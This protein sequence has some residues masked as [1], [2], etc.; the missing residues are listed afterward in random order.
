M[1]IVFSDSSGFDAVDNMT[2]EPP[3]NRQLDQAL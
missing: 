2:T 3:E 1:A